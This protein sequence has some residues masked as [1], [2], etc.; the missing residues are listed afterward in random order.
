MKKSLLLVAAACVLLAMSAT[1]SAASPSAYRAKVNAICKAGVAKL[2]AVPA[3]K[4]PK[5]YAAY[6]DAEARIGVQ[7]MKQI[8]AVAPPKSLQPL[9]LSALKLQGKVEDGIIALSNRIKKGAD[10]VKAYNA[11]KP[12][13]DKV[14]NQANTAW[15]KAGL[16]A[17]AG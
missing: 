16:T 17:C 1:A 4:S 8:I 15:I 2:N 5:G 7:L 6:F 14:N 3:P 11:A 13:L 12:A 10:P 9:V